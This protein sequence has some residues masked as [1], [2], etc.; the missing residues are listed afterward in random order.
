MGVEIYK[1]I[2]KRLEA[3]QDSVLATVISIF[4]SSPCAE[5]ASMAVFPDGKSAGTVGGGALEA[6]VLRSAAN[7]LS[8]R[9]PEM[10]DFILSPDSAN[11]CGMICGGSAE[12]L[13]DFFGADDAAASAIF[14]K[15]VQASVAGRKAWLVRSVKPGGNGRIAKT[16][17]GLMTDDE[18]NSGSVDLSQIDADKIFD[19]RTYGLRMLSAGP[20]MHYIVQPVFMPDRVIIAGAGHVG[21]DLALICSMAGFCTVVMDDRPEFANRKRFPSADEIVIA[22]QA[23]ENCLK[24]FSIAGNDYIVIATRGHEHDRSVLVQALDSC[25]C[26]IGMMGSITKRD[27]IYKSL[28]E[29]GVSGK[30]LEKVCCPIGLPINSRTPAEIAISIAAEM[31]SVR[32]SKRFKGDE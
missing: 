13:V 31:I 23:F 19:S 26:Y 20:D 14:E 16:G 25:A 4:G 9:S 27:A 17:L 3:K 7:V 10:L 5:G 32:A 28:I 2:A 18:F 6:E 12:I 24:G 22:E 1:L 15:I 30:D 11:D 21:K 29:E 8:T